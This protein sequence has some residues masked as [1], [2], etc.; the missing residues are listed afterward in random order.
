MQSIGSRAGPAS[1]Q[2]M[3]ATAQ[4]SPIRT[5][6]L[7]TLLLLAS[8]TC[9]C[10]ADSTNESFQSRSLQQSPPSAAA[11]VSSP[12]LTKYGHKHLLPLTANDIGLCVAVAFALFIAS[13]AGVGGGK[14]AFVAG[15]LP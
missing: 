9:L 8:V 15:H 3:A 7:F 12:S 14:N 6:V 11:A 10:A 2:I 4:R 5:A 1:Q 13:G